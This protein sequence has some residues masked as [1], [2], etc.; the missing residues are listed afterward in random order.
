[1]RSLSRASRM[2]ASRQRRERATA[3]ALRR[4]PRKPMQIPTMWWVPV[5]VL[6]FSLFCAVFLLLKQSK[7]DTDKQQSFVI[8]S[9]ETGSAQHSITLVVLKGKE[10][11]VSMLP[12]PDEVMVEAIDGYGRYRASALE[13]LRILEKKSSDLLTQSLAFQFGIQTTDVIWVSKT[14]TSR[15]DRIW[16]QEIAKQTAFLRTHSTLGV[17]DRAKLYLYISKIPKQKWNIVNLNS[18]DMVKKN[19]AGIGSE[20]DVSVFDP[21][22]S[23]V[24]ADLALRQGM[25]TVAIVNASQ[26]QKVATKVG[27]A[28]STMGMDVISVTS[29][30]DSKEKTQ[31]LA[32][33]Q[34]ALKSR[35]AQVM[36]NLFQL[37]GGQVAQDAQMTVQYRAD[38]VLIIGKD[39]GVRLRGER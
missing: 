5:T 36:K 28:L 2:Q 34:S 25:Q 24:F 27:R 4:A 13:G 35:S 12:V 17:V 33:D 31:L 20:L 32:T 39:W 14:P 15:E 22:A 23:E 19:E 29:I 18:S 3:Q 38:L 37:P 11:S 1:M 21:V 9:G 16:I 30:T 8:V 26:E 7:W 10:E 6:L